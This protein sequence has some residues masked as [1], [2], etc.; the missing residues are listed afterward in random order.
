MPRFRVVV[1]SGQ[2]YECFLDARDERAAQSKAEAA[3]SDEL[4]GESPSGKFDSVTY[5]E[6]DVITT[7]IEVERVHKT[8]RGH[9]IP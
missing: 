1:L 7:S 2:S 8:R 3:V 5:Y 4:G 6:S 9:A